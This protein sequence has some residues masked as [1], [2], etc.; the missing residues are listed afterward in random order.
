MSKLKPVGSEKLEGAD[1]IRRIMEIARYKEVI[2]QSINET[3]S[4]DYQIVLADGVAYSI[5]KEKLGYV[6][7]KK[8]NE[9]F[10]YI[11]SM[12]NR[13]HYKSYSQAL[14]RLNLIA[15]EVN[16]LNEVEENI[17]L[18]T[19]DKK[20]LLKTPKPKMDDEPQGP[21]PM[22]P[23]S[24]QAPAPPVET[25]PMD[26]SGMKGGED[27]G[28]EMPDMG[29]EDMGGEDMGSEM[30]D[31]G[32]EDMGSE[33]KD[34]GASFKDI[35]KL[36]GKLS[37]KIREIEDEQPLTGKDVKYVINSILAALN[38]DELSTDDKEEIV[39]R[40]EEDEDEDMPSNDDIDFSSSEEDM[41]PEMGSEDEEPKGEMGESMPSHKSSIASQTTE[42][43]GMNESKVEDILK[44]YFFESTS[45]KEYKKNKYSYVTDFAVTK[46]QAGVAKN[47]MEAAPSLQFVGRT[48][49]KNLIFENNGQQVKITPNGN[50][51]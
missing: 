5:D 28:S 4:R 29:G 27:M 20:Y 31:M 47:L 45:E 30:P 13:S 25:P 44:G 34:E 7:K 14:K 41:G 18:F 23:P 51:L 16:K 49:K 11:D 8:I 40:F 12:K 26:D 38:L 24:A 43:F 22:G 3:S 19:E 36:T 39:S 32:G 2:P 37:Q 10:E 9:N 48:T 1:K 50:I 33:R 15:K 42:M 6:I 46:K 21:A 17:S 35:Q